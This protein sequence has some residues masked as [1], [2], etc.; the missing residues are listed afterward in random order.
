MPN[1]FDEIL[2]SFG[3]SDYD[4][5][6]SLEQ[7]ELRRWVENAEK[8]TIT[9]EDVKRGTMVIR[10]ALEAELVNLPEGDP[11]NTL[12]KARLKNMIVLETILNRPDKA[13]AALDGY[14]QQAKVQ[15]S[16]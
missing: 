14:I 10:E 13:R 2:E 3:I 7:A 15:V 16:K 4:S 8:S 12:I 11:K 5:L 1:L 6:N 9:L